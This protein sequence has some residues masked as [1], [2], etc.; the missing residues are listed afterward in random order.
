MRWRTLA[1]YMLIIALFTAAMVALSEAAGL[2][3]TPPVMIV[4]LPVV[5]GAVFALVFRI[6]KRNEPEDTDYKDGNP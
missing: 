3:T 1:F 6:R 2:G 5:V 4:I